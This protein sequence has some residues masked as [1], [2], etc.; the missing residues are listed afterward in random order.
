KTPSHSASS[1]QAAMPVAPEHRGRPGA[2]VTPP[3]LKAAL[4][5]PNLSPGNSPLPAVPV[6]A[7]GHP[8]RAP[9]GLSS[10][11]APPPPEVSNSAMRAGGLPAASVV[12]PPPDLPSIAGRR[13]GGGGPGSAAVA[14]PP[15]L[16]G[17]AHRLGALGVGPSAVVAPSPDLPAGQRSG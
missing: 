11:V 2:L 16:L 15:A 5:P 1:R 17:S 3:D 4:A 7:T 12:A 13:S 6:D 9:A 10:V 8:S 14:P